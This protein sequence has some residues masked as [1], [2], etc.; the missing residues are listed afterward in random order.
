MKRIH[1]LGALL[2][3]VSLLALLRAQNVSTPLPVLHLPGAV[4][5]VATSQTTITANTAQLIKSSA[6]NVYGW[7]LY[8]GNSS[9]CYLQFY[10]SS[11]A[12]TCGTSVTWNFPIPASSTST[13]VPPYSLYYHST[14]IGFC[15]CTTATG[16]T[17]CSTA[18][19]GTLLYK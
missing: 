17:A 19:S 18:L 11:S 3:I 10:N 4:S 6:G 9:V 13:V 12:P 16:S 1:Y 15:A 2:V 5:T 7:S 8:N 14:G